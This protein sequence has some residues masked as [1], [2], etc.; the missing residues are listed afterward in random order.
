MERGPLQRHGR[1]LPVGFRLLYI[2]GRGWK[3]RPLQPARR[4]PRRR[5]PNRGKDLCK[6]FIEKFTEGFVFIK[7]DQHGFY[8]R[9]IS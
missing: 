2:P 1:H 7:F 9:L 6:V 4:H 8:S 3:L 5:F